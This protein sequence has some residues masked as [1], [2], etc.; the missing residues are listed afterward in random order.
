MNK[1]IEKLL[2]EIDMSPSLFAD[3]IG[4][5][6]ATISHILS[7][8]NNPSLDLVQKVLSR[9]PE[10]N[11]DW[12]LSGNGDMWRESRKQE[13]STES[14]NPDKASSKPQQ[15]K[16][17]DEN[18]EENELLEEKP[19]QKQGE[20]EKMRITHERLEQGSEKIM[21]R[22]KS[23]AEGQESRSVIKV[24]VLYSDHTFEAFTEL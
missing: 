8:R 6:R 21:H 13:P 15:S 12:I 1:R 19:S 14:S 9:F 18:P 17:F 16:L 10:L 3:A 20:R 24:I 4:V 11:P 23:S 7:G 22:A 5:Q 2:A